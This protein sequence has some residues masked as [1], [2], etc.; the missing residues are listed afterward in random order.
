MSNIKNKHIKEIKDNE[1]LF[2]SYINEIN[3]IAPNA[4]EDV[5]NHIKDNMGILGLPSNDDI[6][7]LFKSYKVSDKGCLGKLL[8]YALFNQKPNSDSN[9]DLK[10]GDFKVTTFKKLQNGNYNAKERLTITN[11]GDTNNY[12]SFKHIVECEKLSDSKLYPKIKAGIV[13]IVGQDDKYKYKDI[14]ER[15]KQKMLL[16]ITYKMDYMSEEITTII[17]EDFE[18]IKQSIKNHAVSQKGQRYLHIHP[19]GSKGSGS[20]ALG[21]THRFLTII[22]AETLSNLK[23][24]DLSEILET[25]GRSISIKKEFLY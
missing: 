9:P 16:I 12:D 15:L 24:K 6:N 3:K 14:Q 19:H 7:E 22:T 13:F 20:R 5:I 25:K 11:C 23:G 17:N 18:K 2:Y 4:I 10:E 8:E 21:F 1:E